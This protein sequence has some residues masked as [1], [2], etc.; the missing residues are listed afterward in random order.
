ML[1]RSSRTFFAQR[2]A[3]YAV[4]GFVAIVVGIRPFDEAIGMTAKPRYS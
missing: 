4:L 1:Q 3:G 2:Y